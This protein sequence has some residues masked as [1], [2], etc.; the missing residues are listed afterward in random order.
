MAHFAKVNNGIV[1]DVHVLANAVIEDD[2]GIE[3]EN[4][5]QAFL[6]NL[7]GGELAAYVQ[8]SYNGRIR[9]CYPANGYT[10]DGTVFAP[11]VEP[12]P[13]SDPEP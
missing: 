10:W 11:P 12:E 7:W 9:G 13:V 3:Q 2:E 1:V 8:C 5:G 6:A 4:L